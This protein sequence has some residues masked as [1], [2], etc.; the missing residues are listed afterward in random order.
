M[1][2]KEKG[3]MEKS[4]T[5]LR[6]LQQMLHRTRA[7]KAQKNLWFDIESKRNWRQS[8][9]PWCAWWVSVIFL[10]YKV[11]EIII[12]CLVQNAV[13]KFKCKICVKTFSRQS[14]CKNHTRIHTGTACCCIY[15]NNWKILPVKYVFCHQ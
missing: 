15:F 12:C 7:R 14:D 2:W 8:C 5:S 9:W 10:M 1:Y 11:I 3:N 4:Q 6:Y 13:D